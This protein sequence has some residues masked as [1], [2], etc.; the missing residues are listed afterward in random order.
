MY[1]L[2]DA[3]TSRA[4]KLNSVNEQRSRTW[5][6][7]RDRDAGPSTDH[8]RRSGTPAA[9]DVRPTTELRRNY[10][11]QRRIEFLPRRRPRDGTVTYERLH[12]RLPVGQ[13]SWQSTPLRQ[14]PHF[15]SSRHVIHTNHYATGSLCIDFDSSPTLLGL[16]LLWIRRPGLTPKLI[17][18]P[19]FNPNLTKLKTLPNFIIIDIIVAPSNFLLSIPFITVKR[20]EYYWNR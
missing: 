10:E 14:L 5:R 8:E 20:H 2:D 1:L 11:R 3:W 7:T 18:G 15:R 16:V 4:V 9:V 12:G 6:V 13:P 17:I 19:A